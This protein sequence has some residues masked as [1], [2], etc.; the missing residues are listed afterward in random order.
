MSANKHEKTIVTF[1]AGVQQTVGEI[2][3]LQDLLYY[4]IGIH[5]CG[6]HPFQ[7]RLH[8][9]LFHWVPLYI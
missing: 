9:V 3:A 5:P 7:L 4:I 1:S 8:G 6:I 2:L